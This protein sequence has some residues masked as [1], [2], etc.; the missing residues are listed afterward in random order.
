MICRHSYNAWEQLNKTNAVT[1]SQFITEELAKFYLPNVVPKNKILLM[2]SDAAPY[3][4][5]AAS[6]IK[7]FYEKLIHCTC[8]AHGI[9]RIAET[10]RLQFL[11]VN[12]LVKSGKKFS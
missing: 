7:F 9:N 12:E 2:L 3:M 6:N 4:V 11:L 1:I 10:I 5:K 8:L